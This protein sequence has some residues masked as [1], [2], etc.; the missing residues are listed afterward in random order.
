[1]PRLAANLTMLFTEV[2]FLE[3]FDHAAAAG[4]KGVEFLFPYSETPEAIQ[5]ALTKNGLELVLFNLP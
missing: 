3:R 1:M 4:F 5:D 2:P